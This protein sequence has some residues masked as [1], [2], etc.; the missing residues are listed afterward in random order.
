MWPG[1]REGVLEGAPSQLTLKGKEGKLDGGVLESNARGAKLVL[2]DFLA[3]LAAG[4]IP[5]NPAMLFFWGEV[6]K[7][8]GRQ[9]EQFGEKRAKLQLHNRS[10]YFRGEGSAGQ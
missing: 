4:P 2:Y 7:S 3:E 5:S 10:A 1:T 9:G 8:E 6:G